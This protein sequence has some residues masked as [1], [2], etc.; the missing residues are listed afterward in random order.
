[1]GSKPRWL[2]VN[3]P[4]V[5]VLIFCALFF[6][7]GSGWSAEKRRNLPARSISVYPEY[8]GV[9]IPQGE[10]VSMDLIVKNRGKRP[11]VIN[12]KILDV[13][14]GW[15]AR[16]KTY[17][18]D[19]SGVYV[20]SDKTR[21]LT[22]KAEPD[23]TLQPGAY[24]FKILAQTPDKKLTS[25]SQILIKVKDTKKGKK[26]AGV[27]IS[28]SY[29]VL[30]GPTDATFEFSLEVTNELGKDKIFNLSADAP[31]NWDV[32]FKPAYEEKFISSLRLKSEQTSS[33]AV[34]VKPYPFAE[35]GEYPIMVKISSADAHAEAK[36]IVNLTGTYKM[37]IGTRDGLLSLNAQ[38]GKTS[39]ISIYVKNT[40]SATLKKIQFL[41]FK[42]ENWEV[43]FSPE[44]IEALPSGQ[45]KQVEVSITPSEQAL[46]GDYSVTINPDAGKISKTLELRVTVKAS[47]AWGW[48]GIGIIVFVLLGLVILFIRLGR[49]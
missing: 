33:L 38:R 41:S 3:V 31:P 27:S 37:D 5:M 32:N 49:R 6:S 24:R 2:A 46:V 21:T 48:I 1:M 22:F 45:V 16:I 7:T 13:P 35:P 25:T 29:P 36:L 47:T 14:K 26:S 8:T 15:T 30:R 11:E 10:S 4:A 42:P 19:V 40:G 9:E 17:S 28:T 18:F 20:D 43:K 39:K 23:K 34:E 12:L 44:K